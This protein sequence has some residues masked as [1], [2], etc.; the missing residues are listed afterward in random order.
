MVDIIKTGTVDITYDE[1]LTYTSCGY[2]TYP[3]MIQ[4]LKN[5]ENHCKNCKEKM[6]GDNVGLC[7]VCKDKVG[8]TLFYH[9]YNNVGFYSNIEDILEAVRLKKLEDP[10]MF[11]TYSSF[12]DSKVSFGTLTTTGTSIDGLSFYTNTAGSPGAPGTPFYYDT[13]SIY[14]HYTAGKLGTPDKDDDEL[15]E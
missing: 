3:T 13:K 2:P 12:Y 14:Y 7:R 6:R 15:Y 1:N 9:V 8:I 10:E 4:S 5:E 11:Q